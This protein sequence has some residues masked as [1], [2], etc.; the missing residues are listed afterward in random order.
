MGALGGHLGRSPHWFGGACSPP[1]CPTLLH[2][3]CLVLPQGLI[4]VVD[5]NDRERVQESAEE[6]QKMVGAGG[7]WSGGEGGVP[8]PSA[9]NVEPGA[10][11]WV[12]AWG[13]ES[14]PLA[15]EAGPAGIGSDC[16]G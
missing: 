15:G 8:Q 4:F 6:L 10:S 16:K 1:G 13:P 9:C 7:G 11:I 14:N 3:S 12:R 2:A 5:S